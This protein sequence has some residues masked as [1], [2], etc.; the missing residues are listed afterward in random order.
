M[1]R[2][3]P[4]TTTTPAPADTGCVC[5]QDADGKPGATLEGIESARSHP[6]ALG[7]ERHHEA[8]RV[9][10]PA[11]DRDGAQ[12]AAIGGVGSSRGEADAVEDRPD[13]A[14]RKCLEPG[15]CVVRR[16]V[17]AHE[18]ETAADHAEHAAS[19]IG[20]LEDS[21]GDV[22]RRAEGGTA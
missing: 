16:Q 12:L 20:R 22:L 11:A 3:S 15:A 13:H 2:A 4:L 5:D 1:P 9:L 21:F 17:V 10:R 14:A 6:Q 7:Q 19:V 18:A 8:L